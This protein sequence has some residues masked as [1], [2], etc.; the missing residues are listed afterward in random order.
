[1]DA[2]THRLGPSEDW[3]MVAATPTQES[4]HYI[5]NITVP[6]APLL[7]RQMVRTAIACRNHRPHEGD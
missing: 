5:K 7:W 6:L 3:P 1:M 2:Y 4:L